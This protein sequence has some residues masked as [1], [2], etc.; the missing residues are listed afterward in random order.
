[1]HLLLSLDVSQPALHDVAV[2]RHELSL[3]RQIMADP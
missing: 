3:S 2:V 1:M